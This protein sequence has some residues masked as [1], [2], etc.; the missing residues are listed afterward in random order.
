[1]DGGGRELLVLRHAKSAWPEG[2]ADRDRPLKPRGERAARRVG[3]FLGVHGLRPDAALASPARRAADTARLV[4]EAAGADVPLQL[5][6]KLYGADTWAA[7]DAV[8][9]HVNRLLVVGHEPEM[10][11]LVTKLTGAAVRLP[12]AGLAWLQVPGEGRGR[13]LLHLLLPPR[14]L[15]DDGA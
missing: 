3:R 8:W 7:V 5:D 1:M 9:P 6:E 4:L 10:V 12:T 14:L 2:V 11:E 13:G 15:D